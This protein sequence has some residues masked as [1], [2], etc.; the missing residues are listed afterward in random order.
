MVKRIP[1]GRSAGAF[2]HGFRCHFRGAGM[3]LSRGRLFLWAAIPVLITL[4]LLAAG[5]VGGGVW[6]WRWLAGWLAPKD[7]WWSGPLRW[8]LL[9]AIYM[10]IPLAAYLLFSLLRQMVAVPFNDV[11]S[12]R[13]E[14]GYRELRGL[15]ETAAGKGSVYGEG[16]GRSVVRA[17]TDT[18]R[19]CAAEYLAYLAVLPFLCV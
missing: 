14:T 19:L 3:V 16:A 4:L 13:A 8:V 18:L 2:W 1:G 6:V 11:L 12:L 17:L 9:T 7:A 10:A 5:M 15:P